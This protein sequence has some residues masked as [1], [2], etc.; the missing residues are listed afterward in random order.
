MTEYIVESF[1]DLLTGESGSPNDSD[2]NGGSHH[3]SRECFVVGTPEGDVES[4]P[5]EEAT[6]VGNLDDKTE[7]EI[8]TPPRMG[9]EQLKA[10][11]RESRKPESSLCTNAQS[12]I[13]RSNAAETVG[14]HELWP[15]T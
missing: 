13:G 3:P 8:A 12:L 11:K 1:H 5:M 14:A 10:Q 15:V 7:G 2:S 4:I 9:V 6:P